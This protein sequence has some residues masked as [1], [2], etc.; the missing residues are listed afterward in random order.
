MEAKNMDF[1]E[2]CCLN[3][4][5][6]RVDEETDAHWFFGNKEVEQRLLDRITSDFNTRGVPKCAVLGRWGIGK[7]HTLNHL[8]WL[9][10]SN[11]QKY[12]ARP[13]KMHLAPWDDTNPRGNNWGYI[14]RK[15]ID[16]I[17]EH[18]LRDIVVEF[19][20]LPESRTQN[21]A[22]SMESMFKFGDANLKFSLS[23]VL[24]DNFLR[25]Q[26]STALAWEW[27]RGSKVSTADL[28][29]NRL[30]ESV[31]DMVD[32]V[33]NIG[34]LAKKTRDMGFVFL[35]DEA[36]DLANAN[37]KKGEV[38][39]GFKELADQSNS[40]VGFVLAIFG[41]G[42]NA[43][44]ALLTDPKDILDRIGVTSQTIDQAIIEL[45]DVTAEE[46]D[47]KAFVVSVLE[48]L[49]DQDKA[50]SVMNEFSLGSKTTTGLMPFTPDGIDEL[51]EKLSQKEET[52]AP[53]L[54]IDNL[55]TIANRAYEKAR[56]I[57]EYVL[58]DAAFARSALA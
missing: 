26:K 8:K 56:D 38:H 33:R 2:Y 22:E 42:M 48:N 15:M 17:G 23:V 18:V 5:L 29:V 57:N 51:V 34:V 7:T 13:I 25:D 49:K 16:A 28:G 9:F 43:I 50:N 44:P 4:T 53:R 36:H 6:M 3:R 54:V 19:D 52:K 32:V 37:K 46:S 47:L 35:M 30:I 39:Y 10:E 24:A 27:L 55:A 41:P 1:Y 20:K 12:K 40:D 21:F 45:K 14:H 31:Q 11:P 58:V